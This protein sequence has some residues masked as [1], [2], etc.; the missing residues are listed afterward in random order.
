MA[1]HR[2]LQ[3]WLASQHINTAVTF[4]PNMAGV[5]AEASDLSLGLH[6]MPGE[7]SIDVDAALQMASRCPVVY[8][9]SVD[10]HIHIAWGAW[11]LYTHGVGGGA[12]IYMACGAY[13]HGVWGIY[14]YGVWGRSCHLDA[15]LVAKWLSSRLKHWAANAD[16]NRHDS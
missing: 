8:M 2:L 15:P 4:G 5:L 1:D 9:H 6:T 3:V 7:V 10:G 13:I 14:I 12:Y 16:F 11:H